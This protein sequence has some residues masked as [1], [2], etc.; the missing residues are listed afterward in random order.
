MSTHSAIGGAVPQWTLGDRM[1]KARRSAGIGSQNMADYL[2]MTRQTITNYE[3][4]R[5]RP[6]R[7]VLIAWALSTGVPFEWLDTG[8]ESPDGPGDQGIASTTCSIHYLNVA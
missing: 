2:D 3:T 4:D 7:S 1:A 8:Q 6:P 5:T